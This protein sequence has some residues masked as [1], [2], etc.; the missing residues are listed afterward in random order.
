MAESHMPV[1]NGFQ[2]RIVELFD[3]ITRQAGDR[4]LAQPLAAE[5]F[6]SALFRAQPEVRIPSEVSAVR[7]GH[8]C[9][10]RAISATVSRSGR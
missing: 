1:V 10:R 7:N 4:L 3:Q 6:R 9:S 2:L 5:M 8:Q